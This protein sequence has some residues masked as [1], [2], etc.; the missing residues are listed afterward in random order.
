MIDDTPVRV[1][2][3]RSF[4]VSY[5]IFSRRAGR[6]TSGVTTRHSV[7]PSGADFATCSMPSSVPAPG[8]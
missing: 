1:T 2:G 3:A 5:G 6:M 7:W 4:S 8:L